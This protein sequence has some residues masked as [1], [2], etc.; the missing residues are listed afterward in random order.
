MM[1]SKGSV[2]Q[3]SFSGTNAESSLTS[4]GSRGFWLDHIRSYDI[5]GPRIADDTERSQELNPGANVYSS[6][7]A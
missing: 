1:V 4:L 6:S 7:G 2:V 3:G 5:W